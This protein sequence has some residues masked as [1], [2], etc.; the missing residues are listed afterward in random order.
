MDE[1]KLTDRIEKQR[2][3]E[4]LG[5]VEPVHPLDPFLI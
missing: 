5:S 3:D 1:Q 4:S 2:R